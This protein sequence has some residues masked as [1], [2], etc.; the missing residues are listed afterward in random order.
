MQEANSAGVALMVRRPALAWFRK[1]AALTWPVAALGLAG[2]AL[3]AVAGDH[4]R[5]VRLDS[6]ILPEGWQA[7]SFRAALGEFGLTPTAYAILVDAAKGLTLVSFFGV[8][9]IAWRQRRNDAGALF[10]AYFLAAFAANWEVEPARMPT[11]LAPVLLGTDTLAWAAFLNFFLLFPDNR[12]RPRWAIWIG[13]GMPLLEL[14]SL[15][16]QLPAAVLTGLWL[17]TLLL[18]LAFQVHRYRSHS[19]PVERQQARWLVV[20]FGLTLFLLVA[21]LVAGIVWHPPPSTSQSLLLEMIGQLMGQVAFLPIPLA[22]AI[23][24]TRHRLWEMDRVA[25][26]ALV[27][28]ALTA[29]IVLV[30]AALSI[31][32]GSRIS[33]GA[34]PMLS[35]GAALIVAVLL[36]PARARLQQAL[37]RRL[38]GS[39]DDPYTAIR[40]LGRRLAESVPTDSILPMVAGTVRESLRSPYVEIRSDGRLETA[41]RAGDAA[42]RPRATSLPLRHQ[43]DHVGDLLVVPREGEDSL[44]ERD[45]RLLEDLSIHAAAALHEIRL[46]RQLAISREGVVVAREEERRRL[47]RVLHDDLG[48][49]LAAQKLKVGGIRAALADSPAAALQ[50]AASLEGDLAA[51]IRRLRELAYELRPPALEDLGLRGALVSLARANPAQGPVVEVRIPDPLPA[52]PAAIELSVYRIAEQALANAARHSSATIC[53]VEIRVTDQDLEISISDNGVGFPLGSRAGVG[54]GSMRDRAEELAG[55]LAFGNQASGGAL[56]RARIPLSNEVPGG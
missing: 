42:H 5:V 34:G 35:L 14:A 39:R 22:V 4:G 50:Q 2:L 55:E 10:A 44:G 17:S 28:G 27:Y 30:Y 49:T 45:V 38:Y 51:A 11:W 31:A 12:Y 21:T 16:L 23:A 13:V 25:N 36:Q 26:R 3:A 53:V 6:A 9:V 52:M 19:G 46:R 41:A 47:S 43:G 24:L 1:V 48:A 40:R 56:V 29:V 20:G 33:G 54:L 8:A 32:A 7:G 37:N 18:S 15:P